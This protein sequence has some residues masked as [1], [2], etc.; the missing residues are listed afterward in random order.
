M[1]C[2]RIQE[3]FIDYQAGIL[4]AHETANVREHLKTCLTCQREW[5]DL[6]QTLLTLDKLPEP[7]PSPRLRAN[8]YAMLDEAQADVDA[9]SPFALARSRID[10]FFAA[11]LP[12]RPALQFALTVAVLFAG[13]FLGMRLLPSPEPTIITQP[14]PATQQ[15]LADLRERV[16]SMDRLVSTQL[17]T[18]PANDRLQSVIAAFNEND[19][20]DRTLAKLLNTLA[21]DP[22]VNVRLTA[23][24]ALYA[25]VDRDPVRAGVINAL[26]REPSP[27]VQVAMIDFVVASRDPQAGP[28]LN[29][30]KSDPG[31][32]DVVREAARLA[33]AQL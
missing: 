20:N 3:S 2:Q 9:P 21:F 24:E 25:H 27:L 19:S 30:L 28:A 29:R 32:V 12:S 33:I 1:N 11:L 13:V 26:G 15:E 16:D 10:S 8:F 18:Q 17:L 23:L 6:Q 5:A 7:E 22:S 4:P 31:T 14:D